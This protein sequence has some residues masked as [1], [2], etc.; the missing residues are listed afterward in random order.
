MLS[1]QFRPLLA[2]N[3]LYNG[4][5]TNPR[6]DCIQLTIPPLQCKGTSFFPN[7]QINYDFY[8]EKKINT[9]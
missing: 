1:I 8:T 9:E 5:I 6:L 3:C 4:D 2:R 7:M